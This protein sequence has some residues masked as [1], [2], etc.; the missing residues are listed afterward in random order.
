[1]AHNRVDSSGRNCIIAR[2]SDYAVYEYNTAANCGRY[3]HGNSIFNFR[4]LGL[5]FQYNEAYGNTGEADDIDRGGFDI[6]YNSRD[7]IVQYNYSHGNHWFLSVMKRPVAN[8]IVRYNLS[9]NER[10]GGY[11]YGFES[12]DE[13]SN[14]K[15]YNNT[16]Y[17]G[18]GT[19]PVIIGPNLERTPME[20]VFNNN[21]FYSVSPGGSMGV[22]AEN[23]VNVVYDT[24]VYF[25]ITPPASEANALTADP[26]F[27]A[28]GIEPHDV[29][30]ENGRH[31]L[32][33]YKLSGE[34]P[35]RHAGLNIGD[36]GGK[37]F[38]G[39]PVPEGTASIGA[40]A[41]NP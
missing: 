1:V 11:H 19:P 12:A 40:S 18:H 7:T 24:N 38:W 13:L 33:G 39:T 4:T 28:P 3:S 10:Y 29:D 6:D 34:S 23:G 25:N 8:A 27:V 16:H 36:N 9:V 37:D 17:Y 32:D 2:D 5:V 21:I 41:P 14:L 15:V 20:T 35:Y 22:N 26:L 30:M 31:V